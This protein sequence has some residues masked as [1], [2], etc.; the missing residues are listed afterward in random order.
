MN[1]VFCFLQCKTS[2]RTTDC[3]D[4][5]LLFRWQIRTHFAEK[6]VGEDFLF[7]KINK[8]ICGLLLIMEKIFNV[9]RF[10]CSSNLTLFQAKTSFLSACQN[11][12]FKKIASKAAFCSSR[13]FMKQ[14]ILYLL[15]QTKTT[16]IQQLR[17][18]FNKRTVRPLRD[19]VSEELT[20]LPTDHFM[21]VF[22]DNQ[23][24]QRITST[25]ALKNVFWVP[26]MAMETIMCLL[27]GNQHRY[28]DIQGLSA[29]QPF[30]FFFKKW[31]LMS[32]LLFQCVSIEKVKTVFLAHLSRRLTR[33]A[34]S[35][36]VEPASVSLSVCP[37]VRLCVRKHFQ[38]WI[39][40]RPDGQ[41]R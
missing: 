16:T 30:T 7:A 15:R 2:Y 18:P 31:L 4:D 28:I 33:W 26:K 27:L 19:Q 35:I 3:F 25:T 5:R 20:S 21:D 29:V 41:L 37:S 24:F 39:S 32:H 13:T 9:W 1:Y 17:G 23:R 40:L 8:Q 6:R 14:N 36:P 22:D 11:L 12:C 38:T 10:V 34:Y